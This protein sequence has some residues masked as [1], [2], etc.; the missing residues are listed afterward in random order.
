MDYYVDIR[1]R[2]LQQKVGGGR[3]EVSRCGVEAGDGECD[4]KDIERLQTDE[5]E[6]IRGIMS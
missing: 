6:Y 5:D 3:V 4:A 2:R 1:K